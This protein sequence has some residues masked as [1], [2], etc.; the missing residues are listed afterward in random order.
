MSRPPVIPPDEKTKIVLALLSGQATVAE[1]AELANVSE[2]AIRNWKRQFIEGG[3]RNM[4]GESVCGHVL[5]EVEMS[6]EIVD[7]KAAIA[8][9]YMQ[10]KPHRARPRALPER[11]RVNGLA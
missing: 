6:Q 2:Q 9:L 8:D 11:L 3:A 7:L 5:K 10:L 1:A 4:R